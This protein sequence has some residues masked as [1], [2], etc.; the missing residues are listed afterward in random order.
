MTNEHTYTHMHTQ[1]HAHTLCTH[2]MS[3]EKHKKM[4]HGRIVIIHNMYMQKIEPGRRG[5]FFIAL[6]TAVSDSSLITICF[7]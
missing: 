6:S 2:T 1:T 4:T 5:V 3:I 7:W